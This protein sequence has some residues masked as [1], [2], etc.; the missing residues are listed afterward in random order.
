VQTADFDRS[1]I[2]II[3]GLAAGERIATAGVRRLA[4]GQRVHLLGNKQEQQQ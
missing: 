2:E 3:N 4:N 1:G